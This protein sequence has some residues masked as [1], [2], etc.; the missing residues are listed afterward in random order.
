MVAVGPVGRAVGRVPPDMRPVSI[1]RE[2]SVTKPA[3]VSTFPISDLGATFS[4]LRG[5]REPWHPDP[6]WA[7]ASITS[8]D[9]SQRVSGADLEEEVRLG[10][11]TPID[12][13]SMASPV[14]I[15]SCTARPI[16]VA[17]ALAI[18]PGPAGPVP[19]IAAAKA[20]A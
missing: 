7:A 14:R 11:P 16:K 18:A 3:L 19:R 17:R 6:G 13:M 12:S 1:P 9:D 2:S 15:D 5:H 8:L 10:Q 20:S 4:H